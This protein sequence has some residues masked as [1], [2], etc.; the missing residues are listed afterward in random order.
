MDQCVLYLF[1]V[2]A[3]LLYY[4]IYRI[5]NQWLIW[6]LFICLEKKLQG[7][8]NIF[9]SL[10]L[11]DRVNWFFCDAALYWLMEKLIYFLEV[12][13]L[14]PVFIVLT[15]RLNEPRKLISILIFL[16]FFFI[17]STIGT[18]DIQK[19]M[20]CT[21]RNDFEQNIWA[22]KCSHTWKFQ[23]RNTVCGL[24]CLY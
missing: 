15:E 11:Y 20:I 16:L 9:I 8:S 6:K 17:L 22:K 18:W 10:L 19:L 2:L 3:K 12:H 7:K 1:S 4:A 5:F 21:V 24:V 14:L 23:V 13:F